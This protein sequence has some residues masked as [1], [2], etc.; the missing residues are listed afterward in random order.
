LLEGR[1]PI[2]TLRVDPHDVRFIRRSPHFVATRW[3]ALSAHELARLMKE[4]EALSDDDAVQLALH[5]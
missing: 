3:A 4:G 2:S 1:R 5:E